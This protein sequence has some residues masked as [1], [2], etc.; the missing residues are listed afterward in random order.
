GAGHGARL[1]VGNSS[2]AEASA[3]KVA[4]L[5]G[6]LITR[7]SHSN[8]AQSR[9]SSIRVTRVFPLHGSLGND[10]SA[11]AT[12]NLISPLGSEENAATSRMAPASSR[13]LSAA[14]A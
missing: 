5:N 9:R 10:R 8:V 13:Y 3:I 6:V 4:K 11:H 7:D 14:M 2:S 1:G 12:L